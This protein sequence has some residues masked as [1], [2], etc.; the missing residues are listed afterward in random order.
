[1]ASLGTFRLGRLPVVAPGGVWNAGRAAGLALVA[2]V[3]LVEGFLLRAPFEP[4]PREIDSA[5]KRVQAQAL[6]DSAFLRQSLPYRAR[7]LDPQQWYLPFVKPFVLRTRTGMQSI[8]PT[9]AAAIDVPFERLGGLA[10]IRLA[11]IGAMLLAVA[12]TL[13]IARTGSDGLAPVAMVLGTPLWFYALAGTSHPAAL[14]LAMLAVFLA[15]DRDRA[16]A[17]GLVLGLSA[18]IREET[19]ALAPGLMLV[20]AWR[21]RSLGTLTRLLIGAVIPLAVMGAVDAGLY[22]RP[23]GAHLLHVLRGSIFPDVPSG[24]MPVLKRMTWPERFD[25]VIVYWLDGRSG[26][27]AALVAA[28]VG[29]AAAVRRWTGSYWGALPVLALLLVD[30]GRDLQTLFAS[31][32]RLPGLMR[33]APF[34]VFAA[35]PPA[36]SDAERSS[37]RPALLVVSAVYV[38]VALLTTN[39]TGGKLPGARLLLPVWA[40]LTATAWQVIRGHFSAWNRAASHKVLAA[41]GLAL[42]VVGL[43]VN[44]GLLMPAYRDAEATGLEVTRYI[45]QAPEEVIIL[46]SPFA[47]D[48]VVAVYATRTVMLAASAADADDIGMRLTAARVRQFLF[49]RRDDRADLVPVFPG[50][51]AG[52]QRRFGRWIVQRWAR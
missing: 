26:A 45:A 22:G 41:G 19:L 40:I 6:A 38:L 34:V 25:T 17:A 21:S 39:T 36:P 5:V 23:A 33:L 37:R 28:L 31:P 20:C 43:V 51:D 30:A 9:V 11:S 52:E 4:A 8:F 47:V 44:T 10:A 35:L 16:L 46:G 14:A 32:R 27:H 50:F 2:A 48:P 13:T 24:G 42:V 12:L 29:V 1:M 3:L 15:M 49:V 18:T 7:Y